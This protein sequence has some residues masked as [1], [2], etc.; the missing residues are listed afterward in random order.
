[1]NKVLVPPPLDSDFLKQLLLIK[2]L[3][4]TWMNIK[5]EKK[6]RR[7]PALE[8]DDVLLKQSRQILIWK[9]YS[10]APSSHFNSQVMIPNNFE[11]SVLKLGHG[12]NRHSFGH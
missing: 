10:E 1:M 12:K 8:V 3:S 4:Y 5:K 2:M 6:K 7:K 9:F 11:I